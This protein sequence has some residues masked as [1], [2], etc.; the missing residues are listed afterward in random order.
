MHSMTAG[1]DI[2]TH[3]PDAHVLLSTDAPKQEEQQRQQQQEQASN[4]DIAAHRTAE[5]TVLL[6]AGAT[7]LKMQLK[8]P[9]FIFG[10]AFQPETAP[11]PE[12]YEDT[13]ASLFWGER[14]RLG[15]TYCRLCVYTCSKLSPHSRPACFVA[16]CNSS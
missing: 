3:N 11:D 14:L 9:A 2:P 12:W 15:L 5:F 4:A 6:P 8:R 1:K 10:T 7:D 13:T 16:Q